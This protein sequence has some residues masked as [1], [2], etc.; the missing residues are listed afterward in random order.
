[1]GTLLPLL[2]ILGLFPSVKGVMYFI[3]CDAS[4]AI[5]ASLPMYGKIEG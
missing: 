3:T 4:L 1:L 2:P 5:S